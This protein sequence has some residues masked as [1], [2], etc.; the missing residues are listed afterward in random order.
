[1]M[2]KGASSALAAPLPMNEKSV[3][4]TNP[5]SINRLKTVLSMPSR[6]DRGIGHNPQPRERAQPSTRSP[7]PHTPHPCRRRSAP[8][9]RL[10]SRPIHLPSPPLLPAA[11]RLPPLPLGDLDDAA[12]GG[13]G[14]G[15]SVCGR[16]GLQ[17]YLP[18]P[19][20]LPPLPL[21]DAARERRR[22]ERRGRGS[23][24]GP[25]S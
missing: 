23:S 2:L 24:V 9:P 14:R 11:P 15:H 1:V 10:L 12:R 5:E 4:P 3:E 8:F 13:R 25:R 7:T 20:R 18:A 19:P 22:E 6:S 17:G 16:G 21:G